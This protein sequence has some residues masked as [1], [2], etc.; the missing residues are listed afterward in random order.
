MIIFKSR[1]IYN[2]AQELKNKPL[3]EAIL[4]IRWKLSG[5]PTGPQRDPHYKLLLG[6]LFDR[7]S[8]QYPEHEQLPS[9]DVPDELVGHT[10]QHRFRVSSNGWPLVQLGPGIFTINSTDDYKWPDFRHRAIEALKKL[11]AAYPKA[12]DLQVT[13]LILRYID[14]V[15]FD[16]TGKN[17][18]MFLNDKLKISISFPN[19]LFDSSGVDDKPDSLI[20]R[21]S[22]K[23]QK[24]KA[25]ISACFTTGA[26]SNAPAI[27]WETIVE[28][29]GN[30]LPTM[31]KDF[32]E[33][34]D[35]AHAITDDWFFKMIEGDLL[36]RFSGE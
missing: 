13:N 14:A 35:A 18:L 30:D 11:Y 34:F 20:F 3:V 10:V 27:V 5:A 16:Y 8:N 36:R 28:T 24:P 25:R 21:S 22:F 19:N 26:K 9:A 12:D 32:E 7:L 31:P 17:A 15:E 1:V 4:E 6:R 33:W 23:C 29:A 2:M